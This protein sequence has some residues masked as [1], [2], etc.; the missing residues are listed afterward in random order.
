[1]IELGKGYLPNPDELIDEF[2]FDRI[3]IL[4]NGILVFKGNCQVFIPKHAYTFLDVDRCFVRV[5]RWFN[6]KDKISH[7]V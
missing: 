3:H 2:C 5:K 6:I 4:E 1:M 7:E